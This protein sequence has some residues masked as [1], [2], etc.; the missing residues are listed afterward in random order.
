MN[1]ASPI[2][3]KLPGR[4]I[5][6]SSGMRPNAPSAIVLDALRHN[7]DRARRQPPQ[8]AL[9]HMVNQHPVLYRQQR[10]IRR[11]LHRPQRLAVLEGIPLDFRHAV[12]DADACKTAALECVSAQKLHTLRQVD[13]RQGFAE[14]KRR[15]FQPLQLFRQNG[16]L[17]LRASIEHIYRYHA[18]VLRERDFLQFLVGQKRA[19]VSD[20]FLNFRAVSAR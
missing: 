7:A 19:A 5:S 12:R 14:R 15:C 2:F 20:F 3:S 9:M 13:F 4:V 16:L 10:M 18:Q 1:A 8:H 11:K 17:Q 6:V